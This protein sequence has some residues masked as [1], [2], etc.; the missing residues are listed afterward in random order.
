VE[1][2]GY[3]DRPLPRSLAHLKREI[4]EKKWAEAQRWAGGRTSK[5]R[6]RMPNRQKPDGVVAGLAS[7]FYQIETGQC[8]H[9][10]EPPHC[11]VL[12]VPVSDADSKSPLQGVPRAEAPAEDPVG[13]GA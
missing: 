13:R 4:T 3:S 6:Y 8:L 7:R 9:W 5:Q 2:L 10:E 12:V 1:W 11:P